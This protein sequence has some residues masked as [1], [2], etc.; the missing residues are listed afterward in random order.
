MQ[1]AAD[2]QDFLTLIIPLALIAGVVVILTIVVLSI[3]ATV[4]NSFEE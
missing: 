2:L 3:I 1:Y 4:L